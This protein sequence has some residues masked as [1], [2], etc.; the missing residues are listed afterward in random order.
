MTEGKINKIV[1]A[2]VFIVTF[3]IYLKTVAP[4]ISF[5]DCGEFITCSFIMGTPHPPGSPLLSLIGKVMSLIPFYDFR[6][7]GFSEIAYRINLI[8]VLLGALTAMLAYLIMVRLIRKFKPSSGNRFETAIVLFS[9]AVTAFLTAFADEFWNNAIETETYMPSLF[10]SMLA[11]WL[12]LGWDE[13]KKDPGA[14]KYLFLAAYIIGLGNGI[15]PISL[16]IVPTIFLLV[17]F[18]RPDW[19]ASMKL[20]IYFG[21]F[22]FAFAVIEF[23]GGYEISYLFIAVFA[24]ASPIVLYKLYQKS[25]ELWKLTL[26]GM[27]LC[28][29]LYVIG[30]SVYPTV[31]V[32][33]S[34]HAAINEGDPQ[35]WERYKNYLDREQYGQGTMSGM[36]STIPA[37]KAEF[38]YQFG[39][40]YLRYLL[41]QFPQWGPTITVNFHNNRSADTPSEVNLN[42]PVP[43]SVL[44]F[45]LLLYGL[46]THIRVD[47]RRFLPLFTF[48]IA[49]SIGLVLYLNM[50]NPQVRE[51]GYFFLCSYYTIMFWI[52]FGIYG[53]ITDIR[54]WMEAK[55]LNRAIAPVT[56]GLFIVFGTLAP[57]AALSNH[58]DPRFSNYQVHD[59][60]D[61]WTPWDYAYNILVSCDKDA[62]LFTNGDNDTF[63]LW[64]LQ[65][66]KGFRKDIRLINLSLLNTDWYILQLK[67]EGRNIGP[68]YSSGLSVPMKYDDQFIEKVLTGHNEESIL[69]RVWPVE[70]KEVESA[71][72]KWNLVTPQKIE[73]QDGPV[74][75]LR[76]QDEMVKSIIDWVNWK[77][78]IYFAV[79]VAR[80]NMIGLDGHLTMEGMV[81]KLVQ[82]TARPGEMMVNIPVLD[83]NVFN[84]YKYRGLSDPNNYIPPNTLHLVTN[85]FIG[86]AQLAERYASIG[87]S[88]NALRAAK[89]ALSKTSNDL[90][91]RVLL[92]QVLASV[93]LD[94]EIKNYIAKEMASPLFSR[95]GMDD[96]L[97][98]YALLDRTGERE[99]AY[100]LVQTEQNRATDDVSRTEVWKTYATILYSSGFYSGALACLDKILTITPNDKSVQESRDLLS[101]QFMNQM[102]K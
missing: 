21:L 47:V 79:T 89:G 37:R 83:N 34:K 2:G 85:Y 64:Y 5:W 51:R 39:Y 27:I 9:A 70:G 91:K 81:Y 54:E 26:I 30:Y 94:K 78:P 25:R 10:I 62:I 80:E 63:P 100:A 6:G 23:F 102:P 46:Y 17:L 38:N 60:A 16:L 4:T 67:N 87:D 35:T 77:R 69:R 7:T 12:T 66:V 24:L 29:S 14:L 71:G 68:Q 15:H 99:K 41:Q 22:L 44:L 32:R 42:S 95:S 96:R 59:R 53:V 48:F 58:I 93:N 8:D 31:M 92:Y 76:V 57:A 11:V 65:E 84:K 56:V 33:A 75:I 52:G 13:R 45:S 19:F 40:M 61:D 1:A 28:S 36:I 72:I 98:V 20:W 49:T 50:D 101:K 74:A 97:H 18:G 82:A 43:L 55:K 88:A 3:C 90:G 73:S 86:F